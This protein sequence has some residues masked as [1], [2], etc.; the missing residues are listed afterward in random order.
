MLLRKYLL[1]LRIKNVITS[2]LERLVIIEFEG[3]DDIDD[4]ITKKLII[5]LMGRHS[6]IILLDD[7]NTILDSL[8]HTRNELDSFRNIIPH[9][10]YVFPTTEKQNFL[11]V[12]N[13]E[14]FYSKLNCSILNKL[15]I[16]NLPKIISNTFNG[17]CKSFIEA[18]IYL[19]LIHI[20]EP[21]RP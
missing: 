20:S 10:K 11:H 13:F 17:I 6:N 8:R 7:N 21:T 3:L 4:L 14:D 16:E 1:G 5:E 15:T 9:V 18:I 2:N 12:K 19:S